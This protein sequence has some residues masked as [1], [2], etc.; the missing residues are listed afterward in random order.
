[1]E[2]SILVTG[3]AGFLGSR[4]VRALAERGERVIVYDNFTTGIPENLAGFQDRVKLVQGDTL[5][6]SFLLRTIKG[7]GVSSIIHTAAVV[8]FAPSIEKPVLTAKINVEGTANILEA[9]RI[10]GVERVLDI[11]SEE[12]YGDF[13]YEPADEDHP[14]TPRVPYA[15]TKVAAEGYE[16][17]YHECFGLDV[18]IVR[19]SWVY[20]PGLPRTRA[21]KTFIQNSLKGIPTDMPFGADHRVDHIYIE[22]FVQG[23]LLVFDAKNPESRVFNI[24]TGK[25]YTFKDMAHMVEEI[26]PGAK[27]SVGPGLIKY[28]EGIDAPQKGALSIQRARSELGYQP[29]Y[30]LLDG[31]RMYAEYLKL[32]HDV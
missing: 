25:A 20:G 3:G 21:P 11:S 28:S 4:L 31:L 18:V 32:G 13:Q 29:K 6:L 12:V 23:A 9:S 8:G 10:M 30:D 19:T 5:D 15:I 26:I 14:I 2:Q 24:A 7:H 17:F 27:I 16:L 1:M 22:D